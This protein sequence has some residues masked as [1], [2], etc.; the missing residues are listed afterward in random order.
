ML[1]PPVLA[2]SLY[3]AFRT[4]SFCF[5]STF[6]SFCLLNCLPS[7][8]LALW[9]APLLPFSCIFTSVAFS[10]HFGSSVY[11]SSFRIRFSLVPI[12][13]GVRRCTVGYWLR[14]F[15]FFSF[16][17]FFVYVS[18]GVS[19]S[20]HQRFLACLYVLFYRPFCRCVRLSSF[21]LLSRLVGSCLELRCLPCVSI[22]HSLS[23]TLLHGLCCSSSLSGFLGCLFFLSFPFFFFFLFFSP[24]VLRLF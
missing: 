12:F 7:F 13:F 17:F 5:L 1:G 10:R 6:V 16:L 4:L 21:L 24:A 20:V 9:V 14:L 3:Y 2:W 11:T 23:C 19:D 22:V 15:L 8:C 18:S